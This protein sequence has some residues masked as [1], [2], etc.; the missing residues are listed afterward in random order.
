MFAA[1]IDYLF[2][3][4]QVLE[5][6]SG[7]QTWKGEALLVLP[8]FLRWSVT[9]WHSY[10]RLGRQASEF[11]DL[12]VSTSQPRDCMCVSPLL[13]WVLEIEFRSSSLGGKPSK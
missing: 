2:L 9:D 7:H 6:N 4:P 5:E 1:V 12:P 11:R 8:S 13:T 10:G 3:P